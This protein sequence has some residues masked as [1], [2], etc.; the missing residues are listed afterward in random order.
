MLNKS[1][2]N[3]YP[4][5]THTWNPIRGKCPHECFYCYMKRYPQKP[6]HFDAVTVATG[7][8]GDGRFIFVGSSTDMWANEVPR[9]WITD[10]LSECNLF[11]NRYLF[12]TKNPTRFNEGWNFPPNVLLATTIESNRCWN[13]SKAPCPI[14][15]YMEMSKIKLPKMVSIEPVMDFDL[16]E[17]VTWMKEINPEF[18]SIGADSKG[19]KLPEPSA[20]KVQKLIAELRGFTTVK[21]KAN[22]NRILPDEAQGERK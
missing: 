3:M 5:V 21:V 22:L 6:L 11:E 20:D 13:G 16:D 17:M 9:D 7:F 4:W 14:F 1:K 18:I 15:R 12:Q 19:S 10:V 8:L 2:G